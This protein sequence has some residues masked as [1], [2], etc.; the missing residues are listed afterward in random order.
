MSVAAELEA[1]YREIA[2]C[3]RCP[4][5]RSRRNPVPGEGPPDAKV[6]FVGEAPGRTEDEMG[7]PFV[8]AAGRLL[9]SLIESIGFRREDVYITNV[10]KCRPPGNR[11]PEES[12]I[13][14]CTP[15]LWRQIRLIRPRV[16]IALGRHAARVL[17][18]RAGLHWSN[19]KAMHGRVFDAVIEGVR[20]RLVATYH[21][22]A[23]LY[24]P[25]LRRL[26]EEDFRG[27]IRELFV[28]AFTGGGG[29][30]GKQV[31]LL[32]FLAKKS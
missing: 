22:A 18:S 27:V 20:V 30:L 23:A 9:T 3:R 24:N 28:E 21:P 6:M 31:S 26:L 4:L 16:I 10:L 8:G 1:L 11:D 15:F 12:E 2:E 17:F 32:D 25:Q 13:E 7:R 5:H 19:M 29:R 14:A